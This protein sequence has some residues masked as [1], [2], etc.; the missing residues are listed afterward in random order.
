MTSTQAGDIK[1]ADLPA[2]FWG[3]LPDDEDNADLAAIRA[4]DA[5]STP[6][7][8]AENFKVLLQRR[9]CIA[10]SAAPKIPRAT[11]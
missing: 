4:L 6:E 8:R 7:E 9:Y 3:S 11:L 1:D 2:M 10:L 5:E